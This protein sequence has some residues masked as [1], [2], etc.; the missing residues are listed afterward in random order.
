MKKQLLTLT[1]GLILSVAPVCLA[2]EA[3]TV[4]PDQTVQGNEPEATPVADVVSSDVVAPEQTAAPEVQPEEMSEEQLKAF[5]DQLVA[6]LQKEEE[7]KKKAQQND[8]Q[9]TDAAAVIE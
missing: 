1:L 6:E 8:T 2:Q 4:A 3:A 9:A 7:N 5:L